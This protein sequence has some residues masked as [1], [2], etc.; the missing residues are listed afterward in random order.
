MTTEHKGTEFFV[1]LFLLVGLAVLA[2][3]VVLFGRFS[4]GF[5]KFYPITV[6]FPNA[7]GLI[8]GC[9]VLLSG[10]RV[11]S[12]AESPRLTGKHYAVA[13]QLNINERVEIPRTSVFQIRSS[14]LLGDAY[15][16]IVPPAKY[17]PADFAEPG[18]IIVGEKVGGFDELSAKGGELVDKLNTEILDKLSANLDEIKTATNNLNSKLLSDK[19]LKNVEE[20]F[21]NLKEVTDGFSKTSKD[22]DAVM[23]KAQEAIE[24][25]TLTMKT[26]DSSAAEL[27]LALGDLRKMTDSA[28]RTVDSTRMLINKAS[29]G[30][31]TLGVLVS[32]KELAADLKAL[33][34]NMRRS[35]PVFYKDRPL[36]K[37]TPI[38]APTP[39]RAIRR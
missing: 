20:T 31:G 12:V 5:Q 14:G 30:D 37:A 1:G 36:P 10:A 11:G 23:L 32:D 28:T 22:L 26:A 16:D 34:A 33:I 39:S 21:E 27:K 8:K 15:V 7:S 6:E 2:T 17:S 3:M 24:A 35:G 9:D 19:N 4:E 38:P 18:E 13:V 25:V 29:N